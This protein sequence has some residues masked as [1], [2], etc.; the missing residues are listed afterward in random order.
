[1]ENQPVASRPQTVIALAPKSMGIALL[2]TFFF[3]SIGMLYATITGAIIMIIIE[4]IVGIFT[5]GF[6]LLITH[7]ICMV[8][9][10]IAVSNYNKK[11]LANQTN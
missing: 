9:S 6:G 11:L 4:L 5:L 3:G 10:A 7:P 8:W 2:L 1:M